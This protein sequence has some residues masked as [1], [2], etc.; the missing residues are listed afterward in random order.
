MEITNIFINIGVSVVSGAAGCGLF[1]WLGGKSIGHWFATQMEKFKHTLNKE[2][3]YKTAQYNTLVPEQKK[4]A[5]ELYSKILE[6]QKS[7]KL[8][9]ELIN[10]I[11]Q[12]I[13]ESPNDVVDDNQDVQ[14]E[15]T[16]V[17]VNKETIP[18]TGRVFTYDE[19]ITVSDYKQLQSE[20]K[21]YIEQKA[22]FTPGDIINNINAVLLMIEMFTYLNYHKELIQHI[23]QSKLDKE[24]SQNF[25]HDFEEFKKN[26]N[27]DDSKVIEIIDGLFAVIQTQFRSLLGVENR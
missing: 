23:V 14:F 7:T 9:V 8:A 26:V 12:K 20:V 5:E 11:K 22:I 25:A 27:F 10:V 18:K 6:L 16:A 1:V 15:F 24:C 4:I 2:L 3:A 17:C 19:M 21:E 13:I